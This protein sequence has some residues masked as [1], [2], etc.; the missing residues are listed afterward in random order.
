MV[1][2]TGHDVLILTLTWSYLATD[3]TV[4]STPGGGRFTRA[5]D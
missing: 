2:D 3:A 5:S 4:H 1:A